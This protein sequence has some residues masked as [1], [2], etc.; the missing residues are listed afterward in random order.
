M[1][2]VPEAQT[3]RP[4]IELSPTATVILGFL[5]QE[6]MSGYEIKA[7]VDISTR[8]FWAASYG[9]IYPELKRLRE[10]G[11]VEGAD[12][13]QGGR[14]RIVYRLTDAGRD[15]LQA[16]LRRPPETLELRHDGMLKVFFADALP[17]G[18]RVWMLRA[19]LA[20]HREQVAQLERTR[21]TVEAE[22]R[23]ELDPC[24]DLVLRFGL[25]LHDWVAAWCEREIAAIEEGDDA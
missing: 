18:E 17:P 22:G 14:K 9:Q 3:T 19:M 5:S 21:E 4:A 20:Q 15:A 12:R 8:F 23:R 2:T 6:E 10:L 11:L 16:W 24:G 1:N 25:D 13:P 7:E